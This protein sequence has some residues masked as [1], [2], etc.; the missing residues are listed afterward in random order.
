MR[1][2]RRNYFVTVL[3]GTLIALIAKDFAV[4]LLGVAMFGIL[5]RLI[6]MAPFSGRG[7]GRI[8]E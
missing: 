1:I 4:P 3:F 2:G 5:D 8:F 7:V 6:A